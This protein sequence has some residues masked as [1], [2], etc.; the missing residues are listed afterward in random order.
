MKVCSQS[1]IVRKNINMH[2]EWKNLEKKNEAYRNLLKN[3]PA[4]TK[5]FH[6]NILLRN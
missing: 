3:M 1:S 4:F 5:I 6:E 2:K